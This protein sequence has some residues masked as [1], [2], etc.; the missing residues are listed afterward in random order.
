MLRNTIR[1]VQLNEQLSAT[2]T[3]TKTSD[4]EQKS[5]KPGRKGFASNTEFLF[6][7]ISNAVGLGN[8]WRFPFLCH[9]NGGF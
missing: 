9:Q 2:K 3:V 7:V 1:S 6:S 5:D 8:V 4:P